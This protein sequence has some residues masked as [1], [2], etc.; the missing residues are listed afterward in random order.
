MGP[1]RGV[2]VLELAGIG[3]VPFAG[4]LLADLGAEVVRVDRISAPALAFADATMGRG[5]RSI[6]VDLKRPAGR[7][8][9][10]RLLEGADV[11]LEGFR[12]GVAER[13]GIGP[14]VCLRRNRRLVF[15]RMTGWGQEGPEAERAGHDLNY[16]SLAGALHP[17]GPGRSAPTP[18]LN[19]VADFGGGGMLLAV[20][21]VSALLERAHSGRGQV[22]D[23]AMVDGAA[24]LTTFVRELL[25]R[26]QWT[27]ARERNV[28]DGG[29]HFYRTYA[30]GDGGFIAV[31]A[32]EPAFYAA[33]L[34]RLGLDPADWPQW[35]RRRWPQLGRALA[36]IFATRDRAEWEAVFAGVDACVTPVLSLSEAPDHP[37]A[38]ARQ[39]F[40]KLDGWRQPAPA[41][42][43]GRSRP[44]ALRAAPAPGQH[45]RQV[46]ARAGF[47]RAEIAALR[48]GGTVG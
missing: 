48:S 1:L 28:L 10:L 17:I 9:L 7:G 36:R 32:I 11:L 14:R 37:H 22:V 21:V 3:P 39:S 2:R 46:L 33:L 41:P 30:T 42:R 45:S 25:A 6:A 27:E 31:A 19:Y 16:L 24:L 23:A 13:L 20:G 15:G 35:E 8:V 5:K 38:V 44:Q 26:G 47:T 34:E 12:P 18:P 29:A 43:F 4:M 40:V